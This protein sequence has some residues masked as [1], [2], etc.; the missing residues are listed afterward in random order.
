MRPSILGPFLTLNSLRR[1]YCVFYYQ[2]FWP[3]AAQ[4]KKKEKDSDVIDPLKK[5]KKSV[6]RARVKVH[7][8]VVIVIGCLKAK[9]V[10]F[11]REVMV[12]VGNFGNLVVVRALVVIDA[13]DQIRE[14]VLS[15][16]FAFNKSRN[17][18]KW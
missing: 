17:N 3:S 8:F 2:K 18:L 6:E 12:N 7:V 13:E 15:R 14:L 1:K 5:K 11:L 4:T 16:A 10:Q 9:L